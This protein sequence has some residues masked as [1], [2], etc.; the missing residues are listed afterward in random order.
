MNTAISLVWKATQ[1]TLCGLRRRRHH[2]IECHMASQLKRTV[3]RWASR[4]LCVAP[5][6]PVM[7]KDAALTNMEWAWGIKITSIL[8]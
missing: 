8:V 7:L 4:I 6:R 1:N 2:Y 3:N 5:A